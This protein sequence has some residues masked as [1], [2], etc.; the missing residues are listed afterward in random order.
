MDFLIL[1]V[2]FKGNTVLVHDRVCP[3]DLLGNGAECLA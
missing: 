3:I 2:I 1:N